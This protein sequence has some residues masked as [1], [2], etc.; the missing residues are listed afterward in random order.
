MLSDGGFLVG[1]LVSLGTLLVPPVAVLIG[2]A[3]FTNWITALAYLTFL[4]ILSYLALR[5]H[6]KYHRAEKY[7]DQ[8]WE[9]SGS[10]WR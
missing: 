10:N 4:A 1:F 8:N 5:R 7:N 9:A 2:L 6:R 3:A